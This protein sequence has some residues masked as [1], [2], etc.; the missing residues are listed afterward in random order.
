[1]ASLKLAKRGKRRAKL[2]V[3]YTPL[4]SLTTGGCVCIWHSNIKYVLDT[5]RGK[6]S[7]ARERDNILSALLIYIIMG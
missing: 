7:N 3:N 6:T 2:G 5:K 1:M 4:A